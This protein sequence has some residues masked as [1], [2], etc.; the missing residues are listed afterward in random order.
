MQF[1]QNLKDLRS[2]L[3]NDKV[4]TKPIERYAHSGDASL[5][6]YVPQA[7]LFP[8]SVVDIKQIL[9]F[10][11]DNKT[12]ITYRAGGTSLS[13]QSVSDGLL[14]NVARY[15]KNM[16]IL[17]NATVVA[18]DP[19]VIGLQCNNHL[20]KYKVK[21]GPDPASL[22][23]ATIGGIVA[24]NASGMSCGV[25][26]NAYHTL[27][28]MRIV[29]ADGYEIDT[30]D[31]DAEEKLWK[32]RPDIAKGLQSIREKILASK[33]M[34]E[35]ITRKYHYKNVCGYG[36]NS[37]IDFTKSIDILQH[38]MVGSEGTLGFLAEVRLNTVPDCSIK[39]TTLAWFKDLKDAAKAIYPLER[40][41][42]AVLEIMDA[43]AI[44]ALGDIEIDVPDGVVA[45]SAMLLVDCQGNDLDVVEKQVQKCTE[46]LKGFDLLRNAEF[47]S[48]PQKREE[49]W[50]MRNGIFPCV[51]AMREAGTS[52]IIEDVCFPVEKLADAIA[53]LQ[54]LF[55]QYDFPT[56][57]I[58]GHAKD[59]SL[60]FI[61]CPNFNEPAKIQKYD[62]LM[63]AVNQMVTGKYDG[64]LK[65]E[66]GTGR[67]VAPFVKMEWGADIYELMWEVKRLLDPQ[68]ILNPGVLLNDDP[69]GHLKNL[70][71]MPLVGHGSDKCIEC[72][73]CEPVCPS[74][75]YTMTPR[76]RIAV[77]RRMLDDVAETAIKDE[78]FSVKCDY[79]RFGED[80][81]A[82]D[83]MCAFACPVKIDTG[84]SMKEF[85][86][87][88]HTA[89]GRTVAAGIESNYGL[90][91]SGLRTGLKVMSGLNVF[92]KPMRW[93]VQEATTLMFNLTD[94]QIARLPM[95]FPLPK[96]AKKMPTRRSL[97]GK[98]APV[99][100]FPS[101]LVRMIGDLHG[102]VTPTSVPE[103]VI[104]T[105]ESCGWEVMI[106]DNCDKYCCGQAYMS[107]G[108]TETL[109]VCV[110]R[111]VN[112][113][114]NTSEQGAI[115]IICETSTCAGIMRHYD[116]ILKGDMLDKWHDLK[117]YDFCS[118]LV[119]FVLKNRPPEEWPKVN[120][121]AILHPT[122]TMVKSGAVM[123]FF[124][125]SNLLCDNVF[126][127]VGY[128]CCGM[129]GDRGFM[130]PE[131]TGTATKAESLEVKRFHE[132]STHTDKPLVHYSTCRTCEIGMTRATGYYYRNIA[133]LAWE[134]LAK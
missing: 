120:E 37:F 90:L 59:G 96:C 66:H 30:A 63:N 23:A 13:G 45:N 103:A 51:G 117:I 14:V 112:H 43:K 31:S 28:S 119:Q 36:M 116:K 6:H 21:I 127:P 17:D 55:V 58:Y 57:C 49:L 123:D 93:G 71:K 94:R 26:Q 50:T 98:N 83:G 20:Q 91:S 67:N 33:D 22:K 134:A 125:M 85:R 68:N 39:S 114:W 2:K 47:S 121:C 62:D 111:L 64:A 54:K 102:E 53:D 52:V 105:L 113:L 129:A 12:H 19:G 109:L 69:K 89:L 24:N 79:R 95:D 32:D 10:A 5:Y 27:H 75:D 88:H 132:E 18:A 9:Q 130:Y 70:K 99:I 124:A 40:A 38:L 44:D 65:G 92:G 110:E 104:Q 3:G 107:K 122:C 86:H 15:W 56:T 7:V 118:F 76:M 60:H 126:T 84:Q 131:L 61:I 16:T 81:C 82:G 87:E 4:L 41:G 29:L 128:G 115:P 35:R 42:C 100:Y 73:F 74:R 8:S 34:T 25:K 108:Y 133:Y 46:V 77:R 80:S 48:D 11:R 97:S 101:C 106:P 1:E 78:V 72:G